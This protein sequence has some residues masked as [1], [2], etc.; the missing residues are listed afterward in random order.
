M[1]LEIAVPLAAPPPLADLIARLEAD[2]LPCVVAMIDGALCAFGA[3]PPVEWREAR[4][5]TPAGT[6][7]LARRPGAVAVVVF[8]N[9]D[10]A[11]Q[12]AQSQVAETV[13][14]LAGA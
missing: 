2:G 8:G 6:I 1:G 9:A 10:D 12:R 4:L 11:L 13:G 14:K 7:T 5:R 3:P